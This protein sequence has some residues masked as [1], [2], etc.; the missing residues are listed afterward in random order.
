M[1]L[2]NGFQCRLIVNFLIVF[3]F[4]QQSLLSDEQAREV[5]AILSNNKELPPLPKEPRKRSDDEPDW[6]RDVLGGANKS[7]FHTNDKSDQNDLLN[8]TI[9]SE[10]SSMLHDSIVSVE[11]SKSAN[12]STTTINTTTS[13]SV[14]FSK[15]ESN[16]DGS[17]LSSA[18][19]LVEADASGDESLQMEYPP[20]ASK[21]V[22]VNQ[23]GVHFFEDGN[24]W[25]EVPGL[26][27]NDRDDDEDAN[28]PVKKGFK[29]KF[30]TAPIQVFSTFSVNDYDRRNEDVDP[31]AASAEYELEKRVEKMHV[32]PVE[33]MK[34]QEGLGLSI[35]GSKFKRLVSV[36]SFTNF[37]PNCA[38]GV[39]AD[40]GLEKLGIFVKT[41]T[42]NGAAARD[43]RIHVNDQIIEV[44]GKSLVGVTQA[45]AASVLRNTSGLVKFQIGREKDPDN[46]EVAQLIRQSLQADKEKEERIRR[47]QEEYLRRTSEDSTLPVSANSS[48]SEGPMSPTTAA[49][50]S[51]FD[52]ELNHSSD[53][54]SL[55]R[56]LQEVS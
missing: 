17:V 41:I 36:R 28:I 3:V 46:S 9:A 1:Q 19:S 16:R 48:L 12:E 32:F 25:M 21:E 42:D 40:S 2:T 6:L 45:Y 35:I 44:D 39:G 34:G 50:D 47:Q 43:G 14:N 20:K 15:L 54:E 38:V 51:L 18:T 31:V 24:F 5:E 27:E 56:I 55:K 49:I 13:D 30:S 11:S 52:A 22:F 26:L 37:Y 33:L 7:E 8:Q 4:R 10:T 23:D 29:I 53:V